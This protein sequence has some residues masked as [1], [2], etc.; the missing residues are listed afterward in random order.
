MP[1]GM[2]ETDGPAQR[3]A[4]AE[5]PRP[6]GSGGT[7]DVGVCEMVVVAATA[8]SVPLVRA[9][10]RRWLGELGWPA[11]DAEDIVLA[12]NEAVS[13]VVEHA[14]SGD[15]VGEHGAVIE[16]QAVE[17]IG[18]EVVDQSGPDVVSPLATPVA[19]D[20]AA[21]EDRD[22]PTG[23]M[24]LADGARRVRVRVRD[25]GRWQPDENDRADVRRTRG[26][27]L[28][29]M[30]ELMPTMLITVDADGTEVELVSSAV[31]TR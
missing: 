5:V 21:G 29:M 22:V 8:V 12:V 13:N 19:V 10:L 18:G 20:P 17:L 27:G 9:R 2:D 23:M 15:H 1:M 3:K 31:A 11:E 6:S 28:T 14:Y 30:A 16:V 24:W 7:G 4:G 25:G 26:R